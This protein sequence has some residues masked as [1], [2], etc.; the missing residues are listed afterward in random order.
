[1][2][3]NSL[4]VEPGQMSGQMGGPMA[5]WLP[6]FLE[7]MDNEIF[8]AMGFHSVTFTTVKWNKTVKAW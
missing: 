4:G 5:T 7:W 8:L 1:M 6:K 3:R 2:Q